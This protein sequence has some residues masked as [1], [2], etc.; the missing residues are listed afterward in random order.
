MHRLPGREEKALASPSRITDMRL[1]GGTSGL[2]WVSMRRPGR[3]TAGPSPQA[4]SPLTSPVCP[5]V[6]RSTP[7]CRVRR[8]Q[9]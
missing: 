7:S 4:S 5:S 1:E 9:L 2:S 8:A 3:G 6:L